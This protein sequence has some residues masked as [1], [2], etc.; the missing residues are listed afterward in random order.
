MKSEC[1]NGHTENLSHEELASR[2]SA[3]DFDCRECDKR[4]SY[5][6][7]H[8]FWKQYFPGGRLTL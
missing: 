5:E 8:R 7:D 2:L 6:V 4:L 3:G 1:P